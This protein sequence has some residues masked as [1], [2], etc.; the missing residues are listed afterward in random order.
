[1]YRLVDTWTL[2][3]MSQLKSNLLGTKLNK[4]KMLP[5]NNLAVF[6]I[7]SGIYGYN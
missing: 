1:M 2:V 7:T 4:V 6:E 5:P 3:S